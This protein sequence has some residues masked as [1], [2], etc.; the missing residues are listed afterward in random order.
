MPQYERSLKAI[1]EIYV[2]AFE[3][4]YSKI[5]DVLPQLEGTVILAVG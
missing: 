5:V 4:H 1:F 3:Q 2:T